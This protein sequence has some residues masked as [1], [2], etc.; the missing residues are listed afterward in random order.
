MTAYAAAFGHRAWLTA[1][2]LMRS[3]SVFKPEGD[4]MM[5]KGTQGTERDCRLAVRVGLYEMLV[6]RMPD[7]RVAKMRW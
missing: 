2:Y 7:R 6:K 1:T 4:I 5:I 3:P